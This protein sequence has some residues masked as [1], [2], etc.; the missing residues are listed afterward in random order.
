MSRMTPAQIHALAQVSLGVLEAVE[1]AG[2]QGAPG[3][4]LYAA[5][6]AQGASLTQFHSLMGSLTASGYLHL[7]GDCYRSTPNTPELRTKLT[8][9]LARLAS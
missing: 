6:Q 9:T 4:I 7:D 2:D 3:G 5:M 1:G 8:S